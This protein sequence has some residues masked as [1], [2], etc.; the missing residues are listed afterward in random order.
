M[1]TFKMDINGTEHRGYWIPTLGRK[2]KVKRGQEFKEDSVIGSQ[3][4]EPY[5]AEVLDES[6]ESPL[7]KLGKDGIIGGG[8]SDEEKA[9]LD[10]IEG[11]Q[12]TGVEIDSK[13]Y[14]ITSIEEFLT[15]DIL[16][17][18]TIQW[19]DDLRGGL[20]KYNPDGI[21]D[22]IDNELCGV[23]FNANIGTWERQY[24]D[25]TVFASWFG[26]V[27]GVDFSNL[28]QLVVNKFSCIC[29]DKKDS[30]YNFKNIDFA[31][32]ITIFGLE[33][34][35]IE[36]N[37]IGEEFI[38]R[39]LSSYI[40]IKDIDIRHSLGYGT[41]LG[42]G[43]IAESAHL[44]LS[45]MTIEFFENNIH[46]LDDHFYQTYSKVRSHDGMYKIT[47][48]EANNNN[49]S[50][51]YFNSIK[52]SA[53]GGTG[54]DL[55]FN[56]CDFSANSILG[57][58]PFS[59]TD[60]SSITFNGGYSEMV[61]VGSVSDYIPF[62]F[63]RVSQSSTVPLT[64][65]FNGMFCKGSSD[66]TTLL[67]LKGVTMDVRGGLVLSYSDF[68][69]VEDSTLTLTNDGV[70]TANILHS[71]S[72]GAKIIR[73]I[74]GTTRYGIKGDDVIS[75]NSK[76]SFISDGFIQIS[77]PT[78]ASGTS[79]HS[80]NKQ[81][82]ASIENEFMN[83]HVDSFKK[84]ELGM[85][86]SDTYIKSNDGGV[87]LIGVDGTFASREHSVYKGDNE[88]SLGTSAL[89]WSEVFSAN[90]TINTSDDREKTYFEIEEAETRV[91]KRLKR[92]IKKFKM[93]DSIAKK[94]N[95]ARVHFGTSAQTVKKN[96]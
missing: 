43:I 76:G 24:S 81:S 73:N 64:V 52:V 63:K 9:T 51:C 6:G 92:A 77:N 71:N 15:I 23:S 72:S 46:G 36:S 2:V 45:N 3:L 48:I 82:S 95:N 40:C 61:K 84:G 38:F 49:Y 60:C 33:G 21:A 25:N 4:I 30:P 53:S 5:G 59:F 28:F 56:S 91:A 37:P 22:N 90:A 69:L 74:S 18:T 27:G 87:R 34:V 83:F 20:F 19:L 39:T 55:T 79:I 78:T 29:L 16:K 7:D 70:R 58:K 66:F 13:P 94:N 57:N 96:I 12:S 54:N 42:N 89:R 65:N 50:S 41:H 10:K 1:A 86:A 80:L 93:N 75:S 32:P 67:S 68:A 26:I 47:S 88:S 11:M 17:F 31:N 14:V 85:R 8:V 35:S 62:E 44:S